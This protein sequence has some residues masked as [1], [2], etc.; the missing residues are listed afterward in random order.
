[1]VYEKLEGYHF[2][3]VGVEHF[4]KSMVVFGKRW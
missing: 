1:M 4:E 2:P 3:H